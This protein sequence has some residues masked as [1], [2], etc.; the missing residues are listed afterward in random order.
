MGILQLDTAA[1]APTIAI[2]F[3][4]QNNEPSTMLPS[5]H[6]EFAQSFD[7]KLI[8]QQ[9][10]ND[11]A[12]ATEHFELQANEKVDCVAHFEILGNARKGLCLRG[13]LFYDV[14]VNIDYKQ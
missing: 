5:L 14:E 8:T 4:I 13:D 12:S 3:T 7:M 1:S 11:I 2:R 9:E 6:M 10:E